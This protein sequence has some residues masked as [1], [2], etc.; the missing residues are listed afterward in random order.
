M[1]PQKL[2]DDT[3]VS[4]QSDTLV[5][6]RGVYFSEDPYGGKHKLEKDPVYT[7]QHGGEP[8]RFTL[9]GLNIYA[10]I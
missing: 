5:Y 7:I 1:A 10:T 4:K 8:P 9:R 6:I 3:S 2:C